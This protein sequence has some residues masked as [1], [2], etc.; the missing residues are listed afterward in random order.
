MTI[1]KLSDTPASAC[2]PRCPTKAASPAAITPCSTIRATVGAASRRSV[3]RTG[4]SN[5]RRAWGVK[6]GEGVRG[7]SPGTLPIRRSFNRV[8]IAPR[9]STVANMRGTPQKSCI[10]IYRAKKSRLSGQPGDVGKDGEEVRPGRLRQEGPHPLLG[11]VP[12]RACLLQLRRPG[13]ADPH[14]LLAPVLPGADGQPARIDQG[15][16]V[17]G[18][19]RLVRRRQP[20]QVALPDLA[21]AA[22][23]AEQRVLG[24]AQADASQFKIDLH[25]LR[26]HDVIGL[27]RSPMPPASARAW[28]LSG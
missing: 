14:K 25:A 10:C 15:T 21:R 9:R 20:T 4:P 5:N 3:G 28:R 8:A 7:S 27:P 26:L 23:V 12:R 1:G 16:Q 19:R 17:A 2:D 13:F 22:E 11:T 18:R 24:R 6:A